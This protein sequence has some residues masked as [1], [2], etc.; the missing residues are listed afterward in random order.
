LRLIVFKTFLPQSSQ[1]TAKVRKEFFKPGLHAQALRMASIE[2]IMRV[3]PILLLLITGCS[4]SHIPKQAT[5]RSASPAE[6]HKAF[7]VIV[8]KATCEPILF[9]AT[10]QSTPQQERITTA[11]V[12]EAVD[13]KE[14]GWD[15][16]PGVCTC[17]PL[18]KGQKSQSDGSW[19]RKAKGRGREVVFME[20]YEIGS[21]E[22]ATEW[23]RGFAK[24]ELGATCQVERSMLGDEAYRLDC[25]IDLRNT[26]K[27]NIS[28]FLRKGNYIVEVRGGVG[29][30]VERF[31]KYALSR[32]PNS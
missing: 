18:V 24:K 9:P 1:R 7:E 26:V 11:E 16:I 21:A 2:S 30:T 22:E 12:A 5:E 3:L 8:P 23:M 20:I 13:A 17:P 27:A 29:E 25:P 28:I 6:R 15:F 14:S 19:E 31:A 4:S 32:L 10:G